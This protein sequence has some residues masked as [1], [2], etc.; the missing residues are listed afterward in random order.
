MLLNIF[1]LL[2]IIYLKLELLTQFPATFKYIQIKLFDKLSI[3]EELLY[4]FYGLYEL[5]MSMDVYV[6]YLIC[7]A[8]HL[9]CLQQISETKKHLLHSQGLPFNS[10]S[11]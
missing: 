7:V 4:L 11:T 3:N 10:L 2:F 8:T 5:A 9:I 6:S 1:F